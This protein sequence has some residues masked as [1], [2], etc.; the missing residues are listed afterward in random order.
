MI[1]DRL[2]HYA[3]PLSEFVDLVR[4][5]RYRLS[6]AR[7][8]VLRMLKRV[9]EKY[10]GKIYIHERDFAAEVIDGTESNYRYFLEWQLFTG[11]PIKVNHVS[12][13]KSRKAAKRIIDAYLYNIAFNKVGNLIRSH[14][15]QVEKNKY[16]FGKETLNA[17]SKGEWYP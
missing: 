17:R 2:E 14:R 5:I 12:E 8:V 1:F 7:P 3:I 13:N 10:R 15:R 4:E 11:L 9:R 6:K 16:V